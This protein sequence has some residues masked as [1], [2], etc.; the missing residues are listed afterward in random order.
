MPALSFSG[1]ETFPLRYAWPKKAVDAVAEDPSAFAAEEAIVR[2][3]V[4][5][6]MVRAIRHWALALGVIEPEGGGFGVSERGR[7]L[8]AEGGADPYLED[9]A[10]LWLF[11][12][13]LCRE[14][15]PCTLW[16]FVF[17][18]WTGGA[19]DPASVLPAVERWVR[20]RGAEPPSAAT[21]RRDLH[22]LL[23]TYAPGRGRAEDAAGSP[24][25]ALGL[26]AEGEGGAVLQR[27]PRL[28]LPPEVFAYAV[29]D[30]WDRVAPGRATLDVGRVLH[31]RAGP[32]R[33]LFL[34]EDRA[35]ALVDALE[36]EGDPPFT[37]RDAAGLR[38]LYR[39][40][41][42]AEAYLPRVHAPVA[43]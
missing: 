24:L 17:G 32:G 1:H 25:V 40:G 16:H 21:L 19:L 15:G 9:P 14:E 28:A 43:A 42:T 23:G 29:L 10:S 4:G 39:E 8:L 5:K 11:H 35:F 31:E 41:A 26:I 3:G 7:L 6:N 34:S 22:C 36:R 13:W 37:Y 20:E 2:F 27:R 33:I 38:Q 30:F 12:W 18:H